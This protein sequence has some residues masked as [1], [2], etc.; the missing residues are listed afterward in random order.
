[1]IGE[2][3]VRARAVDVFQPFYASQLEGWVPTPREWLIDGVLL[4]KSVCLLAGPPKIGKSLGLQQLLTSSATGLP[5]LGR[6]ALHCRAFGLFTEDP[7]DELARRQVDINAHY[8]RSAADLELNLSWDA[9]EGREATLIEFG[10]YDDRPIYTPLWHQLWAFVASE[11]IE[12]VGID[13]AAVTF[14]GNENSRAQ[15]TAF[16]RE[17][18]RQAIAINGAI[19]LCAHP[20]KSVPGSYSGSTAWL[21]SAR[22]AL[23]LNRPAD[24]DE[25]TGE[26]R[27]VR[28]LR[29]LGANYSAGLATQRLEYRDGVFE[30]SGDAHGSRRRAPLNQTER[31]DLRYRL[32]QGLKRVMENGAQ[33]VADEMHPK[34][35][36][37]RARRVPELSRVALN[38]LYRA[39]AEMLQAGQVVRVAVGRWC[40]LRPAEGPG[41]PDERPWAG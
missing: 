39:Q 2:R 22:F 4:R 15:V 32:L 3:D 18:H 25:E 8:G 19:V 34:S 20:S 29:G 10:R 14:G 37:S 11:G 35:M 27:D 16:M 40:L 13:T 41:Y 28:L 1:V 21:A 9:R 24:Y 17:L 12:V 7:G 30:A 26:P 33:V 38:D 5:W 6:E 31:L 23:S 36:P